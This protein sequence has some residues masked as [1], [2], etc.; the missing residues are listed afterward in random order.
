MRGTPQ[1]TVLLPVLNGEKYLGEAIKSIQA[2]TYG[3]WCLWVLDDGSTD[4]TA[5]IARMAAGED[6]RIE[7]RQNE[8]NIGV[9][10]TLNRSWREV[11][12][13]FVARMDADDV[14]LPRRFEAQMEAFASR[15]ELGL[16]GTAAVDADSGKPTFAVPS[17]HVEI[18]A[19]LL[20]NVSFLHPT[21]MWRTEAFRAAGLEYAEEPTAEDYDLWVR[22]T[23]RL[24]TANLD[25]PHLRYRTDPEVKLGSYLLQQKAGGR[26]IREELVRNL[27]IDPG[28]AEMEVHHA[29]AYDNQPQP[30]VDLERVDSWLEGLLEGN[31]KSRIYDPEALR[32]R[33]WAQR[34]YHIA[35]NLGRFSLW[36]GLRPKVNDL[37]SPSAELA[38]KIV[39]Q[40]LR[41]VRT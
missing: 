33:L 12:T 38:M 28:G 9:A 13:P 3:D 10:G 25:E 4:G 41:K 40:W 30:P 11:R 26:R 18:C 37:G 20:F 2:Q 34:Y 21:V 32:R 5:A 35:R 22:A 39:L 6:S 36:R 24:E 31:R 15:P 19:N 1:I 8:D 23:A 7:L 17:R 14:A 29:I 16:L 27:G